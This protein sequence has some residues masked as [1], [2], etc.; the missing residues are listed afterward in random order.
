MILVF[1]GLIYIIY[2]RY[3]ENERVALPAKCFEAENA[4]AAAAATKASE[5]VK[6]EVKSAD[7]DVAASSEED[8]SES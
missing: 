1:F 2:V 3:K 5:T 7:T 6:E 4:R 8:S